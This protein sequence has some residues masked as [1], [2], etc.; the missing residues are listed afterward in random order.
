MQDVDHLV[1][2]VLEVQDV[3]QKMHQLQEDLNW[4]RQ[5]YEGLQGEKHTQTQEVAWTQIHV[6]KIQ[7]T[8]TL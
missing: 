1:L 4:E 3:R 2:K 7:W 6:P 8:A 5:N